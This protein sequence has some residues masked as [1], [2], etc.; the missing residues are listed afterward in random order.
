MAKTKKSSKLDLETPVEKLDKKTIGMVINEI[1]VSYGLPINDLNTIAI[2]NML[3]EEYKGMP[4]GRLKAA[5]RKHQAGKFL[6][7]EKPYQSVSA[8]F[9]GRVLNAFQEYRAKNTPSPA[10]LPE[11]GTLTQEEEK[12]ERKQSYLHVKKTFL[13]NNKSFP[14]IMLANWEDAYKYMLEEGMLEEM[15]LE[16]KKKFADR[17]RESIVEDLQNRRDGERSLQFEIKV[18]AAT[19]PDTIRM[20]CIRRIV[21]QWF[22][23]NTEE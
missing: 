11:I 4:V 16:A 17:V 3:Q 13:T 14:E 10:S 1:S 6:V 23:D 21:K 5:F 9:V 7:S 2:R 22:I 18:R 19:T 8:F 15:S 20:E 12:E